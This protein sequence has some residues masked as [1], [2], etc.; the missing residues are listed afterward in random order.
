MNDAD[1]I[2]RLT[3][4]YAAVDAATVVA[5]PAVGELPPTVVVR[6]LAGRP[7]RHAT[8]W[9]I[10]ALAAAAVLL[11]VFVAVPRGGARADSVAHLA[12]Q[13]RHATLGVVPEGFGLMSISTASD[14]GVLYFSDGSRELRVI[15]ARSSGDD[16]ATDYLPEAGQ[17][18]VR[19]HWARLTVQ[20]ADLS[21][22]EW[23]GT[24]LEWIERPGV[25]VQLFG[26]GTWTPRQLLDIAESVMMVSDKAWAKLIANDGFTPADAETDD[27][28]VFD[29]SFPAIAEKHFDRSLSGSLQSGLGVTVGCCDEFIDLKAAN[30]VVYRGTDVY[31]VSATAEVAS[32]RVLLAGKVLATV[33]PVADP[34]VPTAK[35]ASVGLPE[36]V[37]HQGATAQFLDANDVLVEESDLG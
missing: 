34:G 6:M 3:K 15:T 20:T 37:R 8:A 1:V 35:F 25:H 18:M 12:T 22:P 27:H 9:T 32:V 10:G 11:G 30:Y 33:H 13:M 21:A 16:K 14:G 31:L 17:P 19:G 23:V 29:V 4:T 28:A 24:S 36:V 2:D 7:P 26:H 5:A